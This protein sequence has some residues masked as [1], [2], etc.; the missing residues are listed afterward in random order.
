MSNSAAIRL[1]KQGRVAI[2]WWRA[3]VAVLGVGLAMTSAAAPL[4]AL[5]RVYVAPSPTPVTDFSLVDQDGQQRRFSSLR[6]RPV[7]VF[8]GF[9]HCPDACPAALGKL[10]AL[11]DRD[12][13]ALRPVRVVMISV[14]GARD[15]P[16]V[17]KRFLASLSPDFIGLTGDPRIVTPVAARFS[18]IF[19]REPADRDGSYNVAH[20]NMI[21]LIDS[22]GLL[23]ASFQNASIE[24]MATITGIVLDE[25]A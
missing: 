24:N 5:E 16:A 18:A 19:F 22:T 10:R 12:G 2:T 13:G 15:T 3:L 9:T 25:K 4:P 20:S 11:L 14:D 23:R 7:L 21:Y 1:P 17:M 6:G 8:F